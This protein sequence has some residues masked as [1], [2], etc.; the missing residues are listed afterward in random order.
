M[1]NKKIIATSILAGLSSMSAT[2]SSYAAEA[3]DDVEVIQV[4][5]IRGSLIRSMDLKREAEGVVDAISA[6]DIGKFPDTNLAESLQRITGVSI[7]RSN[8]EGS[9][10]T[11]RGFGSAQNLIT[12]NG[13]QL[14]NT[15]GSRTF[16]FANVAAESVSG[17]EVYKTSDASITTGGIGATINLSTYK[18]LDAPGLTAS[19]SGKA[20]DDASTETGGVTPEFSGLYSQTFADDTFGIAIS[21]SYQERESGMKQFLADQGYRA[22]D[23]S[24]TGWGGV[25]AG[26]EGGTNRPTM[27]IYS[28]PQQPRYVMEER[29]RE[30]INGQL[31]LQ[32]RPIENFTATLD[33]TTFRNTIEEQHTDASVWFN[34]AGDRSESVWTGEPNAVPLI[35]SEIYDINSPGDLKDTSL[36]VGAW[37]REEVTDS[38]GLNLDWQVTEDLVLTLDHHSSKA[39]MKASDPRHGTRNNVQLPSYTRSRTGLDLTGSLPGIAVGDIENFNPSTMRLSG[40]WF[41]NDKYTSEIDQTQL[42]GKYHFNSDLSIDF[43]VSLNTVNNRYRHTQVQRPDWGGVGEE[44]DF[45]D[46]NWTEDTILDKFDDTGTAGDFEGT[47]TQSDYDLFNRIFFAD[48]D[49]IISAAEYADPIANVDGLYG[50]CKAASGAAAGPNGEG[51]FCASTNWD[52]DTNRFTEEETTAAYIQANFLGEMFDMPYSVHVGLRYEQ[53]DVVSTASAPGYSRVEWNEDTSTSITGQTGIETLKQSADYDIFLPNINFNLD[54]TEDVRVRA[55][56]GKTIS[57]AGYNSLL[58]GT[59]INTGGNLSGYSGSS[60]NPGLEPLESINYDLSAEWYYDAGSYASLGY[61]RKDVS[62]WISYGSTQSNIFNLSNPLSGDKF[63][64]AV[65][66]LGANASNEQ[67]RTYIFENYADDPNV[68]PNFDDDGLLDG[69]TIAGDPLTDDEVVFDLNVPINGDT[70]HT[71]D[72]IEFNVQHLFGE[73]GFGGIVNYTMVDSDLQYDDSSLEDTEAL[74]GLSDTAN[75]VL[76]YDNYGVQARIAYNWRDE[77]LSDKRVNGDL[78]T[79]IYTEE[80][81]QI[82]F[83]ISYDI[84]A[85]EGLTVFA[86]GI[87]ITEEVVRKHGRQSQLVFETTQTGARYGLGVRYTF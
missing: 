77:F 58:G 84:P 75:L 11:V 66:A 25:P 83:S 49:E 65:A 10:V 35:Y 62:N 20:V 56:V 27:G 41:A 38:I 19:L 79:P 43:G 64:A 29:Q 63:N 54:V 73:T 69:G 33:Y 4:T 67:I 17:V 47:P 28:N 45:E 70:E 46:I 12:L 22:S 1:F 86:E 30:R 23:A 53:T 72:G 24:N 18:P 2:H 76:F 87:N 16:D 85:V 37:G 55:A 34:Y 39:N 40:S 50:D 81:Y 31:T 14:P 74:V 48:F 6:E 3:A 57:R 8:G 71:I 60:G 7:D 42:D 13:R 68:T 26:A 44:G 32:Y 82:D 80:Y 51:Q 21:G 59:T 9:T 5:G 61:F 52:A 78:T 36:T 15:T